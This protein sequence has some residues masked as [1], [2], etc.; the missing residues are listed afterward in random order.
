MRLAIES[1]WPRWYNMDKKQKSC[2]L[3]MKKEEDIM[4]ANAAVKMNCSS[5]NDFLK[6]NKAKINSVVPKN[7]SISKDDEWRTE[8]FW[9]EDNEEKN[10]R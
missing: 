6:M 9:T 1:V 7:P 8:E 5:F 3:E 10:N 4:M 2:L